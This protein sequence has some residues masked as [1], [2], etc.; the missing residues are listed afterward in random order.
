MVLNNISH[1]NLVKEVRGYALYE[2]PGLFFLLLE[3]SQSVLNESNL[4]VSLLLFIPYLAYTLGLL[5]LKLFNQFQLLLH[6]LKPLQA[7]FL[8]TPQHFYALLLGL[9]LLLTLLNAIFSSLVLFLHDRCPDLKH[10][11]AIQILLRLLLF[12]L[13]LALRALSNQSILREL[14]RLQHRVLLVSQLLHHFVSLFV[15]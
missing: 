11:V 12:A 7:V 9:Q 10:L 15:S 8:F 14:L 5:L 6:F 4:L 2:H 1:L 3:R 13:T